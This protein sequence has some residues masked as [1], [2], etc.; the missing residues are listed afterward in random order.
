MITP[1][2]NWRR[3]IHRIWSPNDLVNH[4]F[5]WSPINIGSLVTEAVFSV[6]EVHLYRF[7]CSLP[8]KWGLEV[9]GSG[10]PAERL[11]DTGRQAK[12]R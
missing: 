12:I 11:L 6:K 8:L 5:T 10:V 7:A 9:F 4:L 3:N 2:D 1:L